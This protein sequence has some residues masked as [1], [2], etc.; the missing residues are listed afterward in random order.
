[1]VI[2]IWATANWSSI[3]DLVKLKNR[4]ICSLLKVDRRERFLLSSGLFSTEA[5]GTTD[6]RNLQL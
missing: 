2:L 6:Q 1:M 4:A 5:T 3:A